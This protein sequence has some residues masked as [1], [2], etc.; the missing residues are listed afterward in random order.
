MAAQPNASKAMKIT[1]ELARETADR[2]GNELAFTYPMPAA[3]ETKECAV[4]IQSALDVQ[5]AQYAEALKVATDALE[6]AGKTIATMRKIA[7]ENARPSVLMS[8]GEEVTHRRMCS[9]TQDQIVE[10][11]TRIAE[12]TP[13]P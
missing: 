3:F 10:A 7:P 11:L 1:S 8:N 2:V 13:K 5:A 6:E 4:I 9:I 12:L